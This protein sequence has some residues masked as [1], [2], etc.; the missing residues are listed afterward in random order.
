MDIWQSL[1]SAPLTFELILLL[2]SVFAGVVG[3]VLGV[4]GGIVIIPTLTLLFG[5]NILKFM[6]MRKP[7][8][9]VPVLLIGRQV[10]ILGLRH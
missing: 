9:N 6:R 7:M 1:I 10:V 3:S 5:V 8:K 2:I 4:G